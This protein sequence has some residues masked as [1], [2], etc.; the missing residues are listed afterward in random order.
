MIF[1]Y[2]ALVVTA[3][4]NATSKVLFCRLPGGSTPASVFLPSVFLAPV[5]LASVFLA[6]VF[7]AWVLALALAL[8][9][10]ALFDFVPAGPAL[11][12]PMFSPVPVEPGP[13]SFD[14]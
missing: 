9:C 5:F 14:V 13:G 11:L 1:A 6:P 3:V 12:P 8:P 10:L 2:S 7:L 4:L